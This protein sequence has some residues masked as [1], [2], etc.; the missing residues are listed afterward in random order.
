MRSDGVALMLRVEGRAVFDAAVREV[1]LDALP[2]AA[3]GDE[4]VLDDL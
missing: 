2:G 3:E 4:V 1:M